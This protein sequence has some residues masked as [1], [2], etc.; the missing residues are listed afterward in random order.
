MLSI[1]LLAAGLSRRMGAANKLLLPFQGKTMLETTLDQLLQVRNA[2]IVVV[3]G[4]EAERIRPLLENYKVKVVLNPNFENGMTSSIQAAVNAASEQSAGFMICLSDMPLI[5]TDDYQQLTD[6]FLDKA[7]SEPRVIVQPVF[8]EKPGNPVV[9]S[10]IYKPDILALDFPEG[11]KPIVQT[12]RAF[13]QH[14]NISSNAVLR[15]ADTKDDYEQLNS[16]LDWDPAKFALNL[17]A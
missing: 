4:H 13:L 14:I 2:E 12:N 1:I 9:F 6:V 15:D 10:K 3:L 7:Q 5:Q 11:C 17:P 16:K 8:E